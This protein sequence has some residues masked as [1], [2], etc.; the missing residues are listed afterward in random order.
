M[1]ASSSSVI[2]NLLQRRQLAD[3]PLAF[4]GW[5]LGL[6]GLHFPQV[7]NVRAMLRPQG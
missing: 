7:E 2:V 1:T 3:Q 5:C 4:L 6:A